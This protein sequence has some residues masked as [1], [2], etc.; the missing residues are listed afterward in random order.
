[1]TNALR[2]G[3]ICASLLL[4]LVAAYTYGTAARVDLAGDKVA[5]A[6]EKMK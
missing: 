5:A 2:F 3:F 6:V 1:M 4:I